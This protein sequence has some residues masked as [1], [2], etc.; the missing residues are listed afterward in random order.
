MKDKKISL[1]TLSE[2]I[3][4]LFE[5]NI[6]SKS[7]NFDHRYDSFKTLN[8]SFILERKGLDGKIKKINTYWNKD[9]KLNKD[10][11]NEF[12]NLDVSI[13]LWQMNNYLETSKKKKPGKVKSRSKKSEGWISK[14]NPLKRHR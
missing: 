13:K 10:D 6:S 11:N 12:K 7:K 9:S 3:L 1:R 14:H 2:I 5:I 4:F 8:T